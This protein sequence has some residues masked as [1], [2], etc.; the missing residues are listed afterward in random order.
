MQKECHES[1]PDLKAG[2]T[3]GQLWRVRK[4][5]KVQVFQKTFSPQEV[6]ASIK[7]IQI[8]STLDILHHALTPT[9]AY[10][11]PR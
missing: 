1:A 7:L 3:L 6:T 11:V 4:V 5:Q 2:T 8:N 9:H 10:P